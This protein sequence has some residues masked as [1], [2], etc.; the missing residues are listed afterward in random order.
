MSNRIETVHLTLNGSVSP[1]GI[2][3]IAPVLRWR[4][5]TGQKRFVQ[6]A[7]RVRVVS[8]EAL[9]ADDATG[10]VW[11]SGRVVR[12]DQHCRL[13]ETAGLVSGGRYWWQIRVWDQDGCGSDWSM[14]ASWRMGL[15]HETEWSAEWM[16][17]AET[18]CAP[19]EY[20]DRDHRRPTWWLRCVVTLDELPSHVDLAIVCLGY[21]ELYINGQRVGSEPLA[22]SLSKLDRR[23]LCV[24]HDV[25]GLLRPG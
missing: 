1:V 23:G 18:P 10:D 5:H 25:S 20:K 24:V 13:P 17:P 6:G 22:P 21:Y 14:P 8:R 16:T 11:D 9:L 4:I 15:M 12:D 19:L 2:D 3:D 7:Y